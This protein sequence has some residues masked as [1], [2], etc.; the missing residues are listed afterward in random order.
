MITSLKTIFYSE[1]NFLKRL[2]FIVIVAIPFVSL[3]AQVTDL[4]RLE[5]TYIPQANSD[6]DVNRIRAFVN[7]PIQLG[8][9]GSFLVIGVEYRNLGLDFNDPVPFNLDALGQFQM[10]RSSVAFTYKMKKNWRF[11]AK[12]GV[13]INSNFEENK[14]ISDDVNFTGAVFFIKDKSGDEIEKPSRFILGLNYST[15]AGRPFP[16]PVINYYKKIRPNWSYSVGT[17]KTNIKHFFDKKHGVQAYI[18]LD[19]FFSNIQNNLAIENDDG[20]I[21]TAENISMTLVLGGLGYEYY[22]TKNLVAYL[23]GGHTLFNEIR[24]RDADRNNLYKIN[25]KNTIYLRSGIKFKI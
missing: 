23:Y 9:E 4:A 25:E 11:A 1:S 8:W 17:P 13:E 2:L 24:M 14:I 12:A 21:S 19:G 16:I 20:S 10:F 3:K 7:Y 5:Y 6:N 18:T 15:N 22:F